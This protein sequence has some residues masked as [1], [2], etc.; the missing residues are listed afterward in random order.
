[1]LA[2]ANDPRPHTTCPRCRRRDVVTGID[3]TRTCERCRADGAPLHVPWSEATGHPTGQH[4]IVL[5]NAAM[6]E[7]AVRG[8][9]STSRS[10]T[11]EGEPCTMVRLCDFARREREE[12]R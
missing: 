2:V 10:H 6:S 8:A 1:M 11:C 4:T 7:T 3:P 9:T 5:A 12:G